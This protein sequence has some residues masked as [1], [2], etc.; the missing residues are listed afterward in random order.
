MIHMNNQVVYLCLASGCAVA[1]AGFDLR[2]RRIPNFLTL[3]SRFLGLA[4]HLLL[5]G[6]TALPGALAGM[7]ACGGVFL[8]FY[9]AGGMGAGDVK[10]M[11]AVG[12]LGGWPHCASMLVR[13][14][15][16]EV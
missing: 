11:A 10:L 6:W 15:W 2:S 14:R 7:L 9:L 12:C 16:L 1:G 5:D 13:P 8:L 4:V 3:P